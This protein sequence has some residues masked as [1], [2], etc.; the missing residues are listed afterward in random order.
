M[1]VK[2][3]NNKKGVEKS[4]P[5]PSPLATNR[6]SKTPP[7]TSS[8]SSPHVCDQ[9]ERAFPTALNLGTHKRT[10]GM[11]KRTRCQFCKL[12]F[13]NFQA[14]RQHE[15]RAHTELYQKDLAARL[16]KSDVELFTTLARIEASAVQGKPFLELM[17]AQTGLT[18]H[19]VRHRREKPAYK[20]Y[21]ERAK[22]E[23]SAENRKFYALKAP[24]LAGPTSAGSS[25]SAP[26]LLAPAVSSTNNSPVSQSVTSTGSSPPPVDTVAVVNLVTQAI[27]PVVNTD[28]DLVTAEHPAEVS[29]ATTPPAATLSGTTL[30][31]TQA[32]PSCPPTPRAIRAMR[33]NLRRGSDDTPL[34]APRSLHT[35][36]ESP[37]DER[38]ESPPSQGPDH[39]IMQVEAVV[40][41][42]PEPVIPAIETAGP[43]KRKLVL[44]DSPV[45][46]NSPPSRLDNAG[47]HLERISGTSHTPRRPSLVRS[48]SFPEIVLTPNPET[49]PQSAFSKTYLG[50][51]R[52]KDAS[53]LARE[54]AQLALVTP[55][56]E[57][58]ATI[59]A[60]IKNN[61]KSG[62]KNGRSKPQ[63]NNKRPPKNYG[64]T[65]TGNNAR[66]STYKKAQDLYNKN[67]KSLADRILR[68]KSL[69]EEELY[70]KLADVEGLF[71]S[72]LE[73][74]SPQDEEPVDVVA[75]KR[76]TF[77]PITTEDVKFAK[78]NWP[79][80]APGPDGIDTSDVKRVHDDVLATLFTILLDFKF[81]PAGWREAR[82]TL[83]YKEGPRDDPKNWRPI[84]IGAATQRLFHRILANRLKDSLS[85]SSFQRGFLDVD[86]T[87]ANAVLL[88]KYIYGRRLSRKPY[89]VVSLDISKAFDS[90]SHFSLIRALRRL[91]IEDD[92]IQYIQ[93]T[94][95]STTAIKVP[96]QGSTSPIQFNRG[97]RQGDPLSP[98]LFV[99]VMD[100]LLVELNNG[101]AGGSVADGYRVACLAF[102]DDL[103]LLADRDLD[104][105]A[106]LSS[107]NEFALH[108]G[109]RLNPSKSRALAVAIYSGAPVVRPKSIFSIGGKKIPAVEVLD[110]FKYL[111]HHYS[112][113]G[114]LKPNLSNLQSWLDNVIRSPLKPHQKMDIIS[115]FLIPKMLYGLQNYRLNSRILRDADRM[116]KRAVKYVLHLHVHTPDATLYAKIRDGGLG[117]TELRTAVPSILLSRLTK[118]L[119]SHTDPVTNKILQ[120]DFGESWLRKLS[121]LVGDIPAAQKWRDA[122]RECPFTKGLEDAADDQASRVWIRKIPPG[123]SGRDYVRAIHLR[124]ANL[125]TKAMPS[126]PVDQRLCRGGC[127]KNETVCHIL[128]A[129]PVTH[130]D[131]IKRHNEI[132]QK[133]EQHCKSKKWTV[134]NE[135]RIR[136]SDGQLYKPDLAIHV[137]DHKI[138]ITDV[139]VSWDGS[140]SSMDEIYSRKKGVYGNKKFIEAGKKVWPG[141]EL[142]F[143]PLILGA[144]GIWPR[145]NRPTED[146]L[147]IPQSLKNSCV[148]S[149]LK[150]GSTLHNN[151]MRAVWKRKGPRPNQNNIQGN[152]DVIVID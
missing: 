135:P 106:M 37:S 150:W 129:C 7:L 101:P 122:I 46:T 66:A 26:T 69:Q 78:K 64:Q 113:S 3:I 147:T 126:V 21:L 88:E 142:Q 5:G 52:D 116:I 11:S 54:L 127:S 117:I 118:L 124:T 97:V 18:V 90:V 33:R 140:E 104:M 119:E 149:T 13:S 49:I 22:K 112:A 131:R 152:G 120:S 146:T 148:Q 42:Q 87:L 134:E 61:I 136:H 85:L 91:G 56:S 1:P 24:V 27:D 105:P 114:V 110:S 72:L 60:W 77:R 17:T 62:S 34:A 29:V 47:A 86:G 139:Q 75:R 16:P 35:L 102:A 141:K 109:M 48:D 79:H 94:F 20:Q 111:G 125:P 12:N 76:D 23:V 93:S 59:D 38:P 83:I 4:N 151:F 31:S 121:D 6:P 65:K 123:W 82:T 36:Q 89:N 39:Q 55:H 51:V 80:S 115:T 32:P 143:C 9:C 41:D 57:L 100:E 67:K 8:T 53:A 40:H 92:T 144:R 108:R 98:I 128:Q 145:A 30:P 15:R 138:V 58:P 137:S 84:T 14:V 130:H 10:C 63:N 44:R 25:S 81:V 45:A 43:V 19:Q 71:K 2:P 73:S 99:A 103:L 28:S 74:S 132:V 107:V 95:E 96:G 133:I 70:P 50:C 68:G